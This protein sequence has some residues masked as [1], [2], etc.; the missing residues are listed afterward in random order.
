MLKRHNIEPGQAVEYSAKKDG[1]W[2]LGAYFS[3]SNFVYVGSSSL[4]IIDGISSVNGQPLFGDDVPCDSFRPGCPTTIAWP[5]FGCVGHA[6][7]FLKIENRGTEVGH[8]IARLAGRFEDN[9][10]GNY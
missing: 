3:A 1:N 9:S 5:M 10:Y 7:L 4:W 2:R 6:D 8:F